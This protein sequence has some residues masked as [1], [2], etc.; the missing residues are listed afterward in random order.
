MK[1]KEIEAIQLITFE[2]EIIKW[3]EECLNHPATLKLSSIREIMIQLMDALKRLTGQVE[4]E[5]EVG[6]R[7]MI[8]NRDMFRS[9]DQLA[10]VITDM[11]EETE[12]QNLCST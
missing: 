4:D 5:I 12:G 7:K 3:L 8:D 1:K 10:S 2:T 6:I 9:A 11:K